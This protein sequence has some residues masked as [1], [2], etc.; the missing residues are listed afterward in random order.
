MA[1]ISTLQLG[2]SGLGGFASMGSPVSQSVTNGVLSTTVRASGSLPGDGIRSSASYDW[3]DSTVTW[4]FASTPTF[5]LRVGGYGV[6]NAPAVVH[7][8]TETLYGTVGSDGEFNNVLSTRTGAFRFGR[9]TINAAG[10]NVTYELSSDGS[11]WTE[12]Y[13]ATPASGMSS[14][15]FQIYGD[16]T[17]GSPTFSVNRVNA[18][19]TSGVAIAAISSTHHLH[20]TNR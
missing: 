17:S 20:G 4:E 15:Q 18:A 13:S 2:W 16:P 6:T 5:N 9:I 7:A 11:S 14:C 1:K 10:T 8:A 19:A 3:L 12:S